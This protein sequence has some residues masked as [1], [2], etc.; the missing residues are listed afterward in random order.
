[1]GKSKQQQW[2]EKHPDIVQTAQ[3]EYNKKRP[4]WSFRPTPEN[5]QWLEE[6]R[7]NDDND[8]PESDATLLN[9]KLN[10]L[11]LLEQ[12]GF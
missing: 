4:V 12:Q 5:I 11:R 10:K 7:W 8:K 3:A 2:N 6:E 1:M 9:R